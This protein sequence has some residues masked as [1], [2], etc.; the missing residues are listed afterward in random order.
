MTT[1]EQERKALERIRKIVEL[2]DDLDTAG[3]RQAVIDHRI[4]RRNLEYTNALI[5]RIVHAQG[6]RA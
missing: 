3:F 5:G 4:A 1:K 2:A 6:A